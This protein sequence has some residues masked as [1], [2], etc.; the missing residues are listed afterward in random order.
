MRTDNVL[1]ASDFLLAADISY[2]AKLVYMILLSKT[3]KHGTTASLRELARLSGMCVNTI[4]N[5]ITELVCAHIIS[6]YPHIPG[7]QGVYKLTHVKKS[8]TVAI[9]LYILHN[10]TIQPLQKVLYALLCVYKRIGKDDSCYPGYKTLSQALGVCKRTVQRTV[11]GLRL[12]GCIKTQLIRSIDK[13]PYL[14]Y[15]FVAF[16]DF[17]GNKEDIETAKEESMYRNLM[18][19]IYCKEQEKEEVI[20]KKKVCDG[21]SDSNTDKNKDNMNINISDRHYITKTHICQENFSNLSESEIECN[22]KVQ[23]GYY[24]ILSDSP[25]LHNDIDACIRCLIHALQVAAKKGTIMS[26]GVVYTYTD[27][28]NKLSQLDGEHI[29]LAIK[30]YQ[31]KSQSTLI[32][33]PAA[34]MLAIILGTI[35]DIDLHFTN[36]VQYDFWHT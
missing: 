33:H 35:D 36:L 20:D 10:H 32:K 31:Q 9:P 21:T 14:C 25:E 27:L 1:V 12:L 34:Y 16:D 24:D 8:C 13:F 17:G 7:E 28:C 30:R 18:C 23:I 29:L 5:A 3:S 11:N 26:R 19:H 4:R 22:I 2:H 6:K 15:F